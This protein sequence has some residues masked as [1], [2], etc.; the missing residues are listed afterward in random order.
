[1]GTESVL[2]NVSPVPNL[3]HLLVTKSRVNLDKPFRVLYHPKRRKSVFWSGSVSS[4]I[5]WIMGRLT[6]F[7]ANPLVWTVPLSSVKRIPPA[8]SR[9]SMCA[10]GPSNKSS[11]LFQSTNLLF[12][13]YFSKSSNPKSTKKSWLFCTPVITGWPSDYRNISKPL[14]ISDPRRDSVIWHFATYPRESCYPC[15]H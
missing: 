8:Q 2:E 10:M 5:K 3:R 11:S 13:D 14:T 9:V 7:A 4:R 1:M 6:S 12:A 15:C